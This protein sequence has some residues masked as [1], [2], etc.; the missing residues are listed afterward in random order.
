M[1]GS[2][3]SGRSTGTGGAGNGNTSRPARVLGV[4]GPSQ[5][6][7]VTARNITLFIDILDVGPFSGKIETKA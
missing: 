5:D 7:I 4:G 3:N 1:L 2:P 6:A